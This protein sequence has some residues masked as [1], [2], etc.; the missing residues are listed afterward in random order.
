[1]DDYSPKGKIIIKYDNKNFLNLGK[2]KDITNNKD[3][4]GIIGVGS[5]VLRNLKILN[6][7]QSFQ[8]IQ[9]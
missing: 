3:L 7:R 4:C 5:S 6:M 1:M 8:K 9:S 2:I